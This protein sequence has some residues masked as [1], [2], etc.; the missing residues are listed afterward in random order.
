MKVENIKNPPKIIYACDVCGKF[1]KPE[2]LTTHHTPD[3]WYSS[4]ETY[5][6]CKFCIEKSKND[7]K[8]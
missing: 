4:E 3:S 1:R 5:F 6:E 7:S 8:V 2:S